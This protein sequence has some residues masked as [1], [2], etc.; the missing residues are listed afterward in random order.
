MSFGMT[1][2]E[3]DYAIMANA[4]ATYKKGKEQIH[5]N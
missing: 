5:R 3:L 1:F 4:G 2:S